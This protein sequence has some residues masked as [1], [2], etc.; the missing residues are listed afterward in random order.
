MLQKWF[1][2]VI[3]LSIIVTI[4]SL[5]FSL[6]LPFFIHN[7]DSKHFSHKLKQSCACILPIIKHVSAPFHTLIKQVFFCH[8]YQFSFFSVDLFLFLIIMSVCLV[9]Q[10]LKQLRSCIFTIISNVCI[11]LS[12][13]T[14]MLFSCLLILFT[15]SS[16]LFLFI[17]SC[18]A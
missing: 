17:L 12:H 18:F 16:S 8:Y 11:P 2:T 3:R 1:C 5:F 10:I 7:H 14:R 6:C 9:L 15:F 4:H 13:I